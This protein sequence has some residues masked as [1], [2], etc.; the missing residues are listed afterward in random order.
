MLP[1]KKE[2]RS[3]YFNPAIFKVV[4]IREPEVVPAPS[5]LQSKINYAV[6]NATRHCRGCK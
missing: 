5:T 4:E 3:I 2:K 6:H 1:Q